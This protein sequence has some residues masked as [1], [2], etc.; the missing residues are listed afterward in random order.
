M[1][2]IP[3]SKPQ[4]SVKPS[5]PVSEVATAAPV[6][7]SVTPE[8][9]VQEVAAVAAPVAAPVVLTTSKA[10]VAQAAT[11]ATTLETLYSRAVKAAQEEGVGA[12]LMVERTEIELFEDENF[13][14]NYNE[15]RLNV[16][17]VKQCE[18]EALT[19]PFAVAG[20][21]IGSF[22]LEEPLPAN[23]RQIYFGTNSQRAQTN[24]QT[25]TNSQRAQRAA[26]EHSE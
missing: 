16:C 19:V 3:Q 23:I 17:R 11:E 6:V 24:S 21:K 13:G 1:A 25:T 2:V 4:T 10:P 9:V 12:T 8:P 5:T 22:L 14:Y 26:N 15:S 20:Y 7:Q 18:K